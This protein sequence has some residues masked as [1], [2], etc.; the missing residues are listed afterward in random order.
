MKTE[1]DLRE[2][3]T[4]EMVTVK[5]HILTASHDYTGEISQRE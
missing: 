2:I 4:K 3:E 1:K 5:Q